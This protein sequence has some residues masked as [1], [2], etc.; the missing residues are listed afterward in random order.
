M[1]VYE[2]G[3]WFQT[4]LNSVAAQDYSNLKSLFLLAGDS[5]DLP[6]MIRA[7]VPNAFVRAVDGNPGFGTAANEVLRLVEG[8]N[9]FFCFLHD[10]VALDA[11]AIRVLVEEVYRS[12]GGIV[13]PKLVEWNSPR[14][15]QHVGL[16]VDRFG[17]VDAMVE[18]GELDQ[19]QHDAVRDVFAVPTAC[20]MVRA[21]LFRAIGGFDPTIEYSGDDVDLCWRAHLGGARVLVVPAARVRHLERLEERRPDAVSAA[22]TSRTRMRTVLTLTGAQRLPLLVLQLI[23]MTV[24]ESI[25]FLLTGRVRLMLASMG[26]LLGIVP[27]FPSYLSR[28]RSIAPLRSVPDREIAGLQLRGSARFATYMRS[29]DARVV[30]TEFTTERRW[31]QTAGSAPAIA[32]LSVTVLTLLGSRTLITGGVPKFGEF[33]AFPASPAELL[34][35]YLSGWSGHGLG[36]TSAAPTGLA[37][38]ALGSVVTLFHMAALHTVCV[39]GLLFVGYLGIWRL[40]SMFPTARA[41]VAALVVYAAVPLPSQLLAT[42]R[43]GALA[44]YAATPWAVHLL[45]RL[46]GVESSGSF[47]APPSSSSIETP[48]HYSQPATRKMVRL[49]AQLALVT[50]FAFAFAPSFVVVL[51]GVGFVLAVSTLLVGGGTGNLRAAAT[52]AIA[53]VVAVA[54]AV[55]ANLPW[56]ASLTGSDGW[57]AVVGVPG[58]SARSLGVGRLARFLD[59][60]GGPGVLSL[61]IFLPV[62]AAPLIARAWRFAWAMRA[63]ALV[64]GFGILLVLDDR[65]K[66]P[67]R[68]PEPG[69][70]LAPVAVGVALAAAVTVAAL[71]ED[72]L[73]GSFGWRQPL[74]LISAVAIVIGLVP[75]T[76]SVVNGRWEMPERTLVSVLGQ[77]PVNPAEGDYRVLWIG[78]PRAIPV[79]SYTYTTGIGYAITDDDLLSIEDYWAGTPT[80]VETDVAN[81]LSDIADGLTLRGGRL[82]APFG[83]RFV[84]VPLA[85]GANGTIDNPLTAPAGLIDVLNDQLDLAAPLTKPPNYIVYENTAYTPTRSVLSA[86]GAAASQQAGGEVLAQADLRGSVPFAVGSPD[87]GAAVGDVAAG[88]LHVAVPYDSHWQLTVDGQRVAGR[89]AFGSTLAFDMPAGGQASLVYDTGTTRSLWLVG[90]LVVWLV[91]LVAASRLRPA[92]LMRRRAA[93]GAVIDRTPVADLTAVVQLPRETR[94]TSEFG[95]PIDFGEPAGPGGGL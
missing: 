23:V 10:D 15:L 71:R 85:D 54:V 13:G 27:R 58:A 19:E 51:I 33:L 36:S 11:G 81:A 52:M 68:M 35:N 4:V 76:L 32:W 8:E 17:E 53:A 14:V 78:D 34:S 57:T 94:E 38:I 66:L 28:R 6:A 77:L 7:A 20:M 83:I 89:R 46:A 56:A 50:A 16:A 41:R 95:E 30:D 73:S 93:S 3:D 86:K 90:Q 69:V 24:S 72:V 60:G 62:V 25:M 79:G 64:A 5:A 37:L 84:V 26:S 61:V 40:S 88:T 29:R 49:F 43:W 48:E 42:G 67:W 47:S 59:T 12:N 18:P 65:G 44:C 55:V 87:R 70:L 9:G 1:V 21:D 82:L 80:S 2:P 31:R 22:R 92:Q 74:G 75:G 45:R 39:V 91:L 63:M